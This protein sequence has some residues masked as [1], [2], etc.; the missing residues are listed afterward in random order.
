MNAITSNAGVH[1][2]EGGLCPSVALRLIHQKMR[3]LFCRIVRT[4][5]IPVTHARL[6]RQEEFILL[7]NI[8][9]DA[10][11]CSVSYVSVGC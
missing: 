2:C 10:L 11:Q 9:L 4:G 7:W 8:S 3:F 1:I 6:N 5:M